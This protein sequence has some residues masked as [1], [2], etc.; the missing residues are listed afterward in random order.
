MTYPDNL[1]PDFSARDIADGVDHTIA[2]R[3]SPRAFK[4]VPVSDQDVNI[5]FE[6]ARWAPS[7]FNAQPWV[8]YVSNDNTFEQYLSLLVEGNQVWAKN[9]SLI[10]F[11]VVKKSFEHNGKPNNYAEFDAGAA[12]MAMSLQARQM[13]LYTHGMGGIHHQQVAE[14][15]ALDDDHKVVCGFVIGVAESPDVLPAEVAAKEKP[16]ARKPL[17]QVLRR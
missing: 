5:L 11:V 14:Y 7:C 12:W 16:S 3:W 2:H 15:L 9:A 10:G 8:F 13:G 6:A 17:L 1:T 4:K